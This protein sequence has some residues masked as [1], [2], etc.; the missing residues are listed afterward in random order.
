MATSALSAPLS[1][2]VVE[3]RAGEQIIYALP[4]AGVLIVGGDL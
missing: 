1:R 4:G 2:P 3:Q